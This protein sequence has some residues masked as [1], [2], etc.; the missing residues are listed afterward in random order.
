MAGD[1]NLGDI[2]WSADVPLAINQA[3]LTQHNRLLR[4]TEDF[5]LTQH[6][7]CLT[8]PSSGKTLDLLFSSYPHVISDVH[9][10]PGMSDHLAILFHINVK[11][12]RLFKPPHKV[13]DYK[14]ADF[15]GLR[16]S[17]SVYTEHFFASAPQNFTVE[18][19][20][21]R[22]K[23][24]LTKAMAYYIPQRRSSMRYK[25]PWI[26]SE[27]K[28][29]M[30]KK[31]RL[32]KKA[33]R[34]QNQDHWVEFKKQ[35][36]L[37]SRL[38]K[39]SRSNYL[40]NVI[41]AS[42]QESPKKFWSYVRSCKSEAIG[43]PPLRYG[44]NLFSSDQSKAEALNSYFFSVFTQE[45]QPI[46]TKPISPYNPI[47]DID[48]STHGVYK[49]LLQ[50]N[51]RK[52][53]GPDEIPARVLKELAPSVASWLSFIFQQSYDTGAVPS[54][55]TKALV[56]AIHKKDSKSNPANNRPVSLTSLCCK[57]ME[58]IIL[59]HIA[60]HLAVNNIL[61]DQQHG[62]RQRFSCETQL[63]SA[64]NDW[65]KCINSCSQT[66]VILLDFS[67]AFD[68]V[69]H[70]RLLLKLDYYAIRGKTAA[71]I[72]AFLSNRSQVVSVNGS[73]S[74]PRPVPSGVP[75]G[76]V[77]GPVLFLL[78][79]ND[80][81]DHIQSTMRLF[82]DDSIVYREIK[83]TRDH[84][85]LQQDL[86]S[87][88]EWAE[89]WQLNFNI[90]KCYHLG[91]TNKVVPFSCNYLMNDIVITK[92]ASTKYLGVTISHNLNWNQHCDN[93]CSKANSMLGLLRR[94]LSDCSVD[95]KCK[96]YTTLV[97]PQLEYACSVWNPFTK[98]NVHQIELVQH[99]AARFVFRDYSNF[100][101]V[102]PMLKQL[103]WDTLEQR[104]LSHQLSMFYKIQQGL[105]GISLPPEVCPL[106]RASR[107][108]N[109][110]PFRHIQSNCDVYKY[111]FYPSSIVAWNK[112]PIL[113]DTFP[114]TSCIMSTINSMIGLQ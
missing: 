53:C 13:F 78:Y 20:W 2:D 23:V 112:L 39:E 27:I 21:S 89:T 99:R 49:Q 1:F 12:T 25:L 11:A 31:D 107:L 63:I 50:L 8:C 65:A 88:C 59:S 42:L 38:I 19:N 45:R 15:E 95:V 22:F 46:P 101:H 60:K 4:I 76:S 62:F 97:R 29:Q 87:L 114:S 40:N 17:M 26:T 37:V 75:Q 14:R 79:I 24:T 94:V 9:T 84:A 28:R 108:P 44:N 96:A 98:R 7:K 91:V 106:T 100:T 35:R 55:W 10:V 82:A 90:S 5:S 16:K 6:V 54:D 51:P 48:I 86:I 77:L 58:H 56:T 32:H 80:I 71:W 64:V 57:V 3:T 33:L 66:D 102:T 113:M 85:L 104:R 52:A 41:G 81:T 68:S 92:S 83:N 70:Q 111:S 34:Y 47:S 61:I 72:K 109:A 93:V 74:S 69:P 43:I 110:F 105:V 30:R 18:D 36:N 67:K 103:G 73:H